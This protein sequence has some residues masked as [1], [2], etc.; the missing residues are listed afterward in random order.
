MKIARGVHQSAKGR[1]R[2]MV[3]DTKTGKIK[4][5]Y[6]WQN[7]LILNQGM[8]AIATTYTWANAFL[9]CAAGT[10][11]TPTQDDS[12]ATTATQ[13]GTTVTLSGGSFVFT[14]TGTDA[15]KMIKWDSG[16]EA[17]VVTVTNP[18]TVVVDRS[19][20]VSAEVFTVYRTN[21]TGLTTEVKRTNTYLTGV[22]NCGTTYTADEG[23]M[24]MRRTFDFTVETGDVTYT[25]IGFAN[26]ATVA[27]NLF[28]RILLSSPVALIEDDALRVV[29]DLSIQLAW[30]A[31]RALSPSISG[32]IYVSGEEMI[33]TFSLAEVSTTGT[34]TT[35]NRTANEPSVS[36]SVRIAISDSTTALQA[37]PGTGT[38]NNRTGT[39]RFSKAISLSAYTANTFTRTK[40]V[41]YTAAEGNMSGI[42]SI[43]IGIY[44]AATTFYSGIAFLMDSAQEKLNTHS[45]SLSFTYTW[46]RV[47]G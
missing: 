20:S 42:R 35:T 28:S 23:L 24:V 46:S 22:G 29:Y 25:E 14:D 40:S 32:W 13:S 43:F 16:E 38:L 6:G 3:V 2:V 4:R 10:G 39:E 21:Q 8:N 30:Y 27:A 11:T 37:E 5:D 41:T 33:E 36:S 7:N 31:P 9:R 34:V 18:T 47:L 44:S 15:G 19:Q 12:G 17:M 1:V 26:S 45:L